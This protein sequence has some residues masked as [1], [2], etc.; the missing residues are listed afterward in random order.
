MTT[1][2]HYTLTS[3]KKIAGRFYKKEIICEYDTNYENYATATCADTMRWFRRTGSKQ[4]LK[5]EIKT[6][7]ATGKRYKVMTLYSYA[8]HDLT[9]R[10]VHKWVEII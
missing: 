10:N 7:K 3:E 8:P 1:K 5:H 6:D 2:Y 4:R 9:Y